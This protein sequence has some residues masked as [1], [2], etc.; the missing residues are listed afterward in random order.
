VAGDPVVGNLAVRIYDQWK[1]TDPREHDE[2]GELEEAL[3]EANQLADHI[4][5]L[6]QTAESE[7]DWA[8]IARLQRRLDDLIRGA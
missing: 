3:T 4:D 7:A 2:S 1:T 6:T 8:E 5:E